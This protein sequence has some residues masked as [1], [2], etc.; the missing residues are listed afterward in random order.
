MY[1]TIWCYKT[2]DSKKY[3]SFEVKYP[4]TR[5]QA[6]FIAKRKHS[7]K[8]ILEMI[9]CSMLINKDSSF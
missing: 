6:I 2:P 3:A 7:I 1:S 5:N 4:I 8:V 9:P